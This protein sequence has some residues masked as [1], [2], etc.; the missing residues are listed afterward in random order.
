MIQIMSGTIAPPPTPRARQGLT[1]QAATYAASGRDR[2]RHGIRACQGPVRQESDG[3]NYFLNF[4]SRRS[5]ELLAT[6]LQDAVDKVS[7][8]L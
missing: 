4:L 6:T 1:Q 7:L 8:K 5:A 3:L 2:R